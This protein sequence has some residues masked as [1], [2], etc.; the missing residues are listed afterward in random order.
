MTQGQHRSQAAS[1]PMRLFVAIVLSVALAA[2]Q[3]P[4]TT[5]GPVG[6]PG[7]TLAGSNATREPAAGALPAP[8]LRSAD[9]IAAAM[10]DSSRAEQVVVSMLA[11]LGIGLYEPDGS[12]IRAGTETSD[13]DFFVFEPAAHGLANMLRDRT[14]PD[15]QM[16]FR[17]FHAALVSIGYGGSADE[18]ATAYASSYAAHPDAPMSRLVGPLEPVDVEATL[19]S[20]ELWLLLVDG[21]VRPSAAATAMAMSGDGIPPVAAA[22]AGGGWGVARRSVQTALSRPTS[23]RS[24]LAAQ[25]QAI[26]GA[27]RIT[28]TASPVAVHEGHGGPGSPTVVTAHLS[29]PVEPLTSPFTGA[30]IVPPASGPAGL[31]IGWTD[32]AGA[33]KHGSLDAAVTPADEDGEAETTWTPQQEEAD[34]KGIDREEAGQIHGGFQRQ[35]LLTQLYGAFVAPYIGFITRFKEAYAILRIGW[36]EKAEAVVKI[37][38][39]D[40]YDG[41][42][43]TITFLGDLT[44]IQPDCSTLPP[45]DGPCSID[46]A[47]MYMGEGT[48]SGS[49]AGWAA[50]NPG[51]D[52]VPSGTVD[53]TFTAGVDGNT[54]TIG[55]YAN[56]DTN[57]SGVITAPFTVTVDAGTASATATYGP[58]PMVGEL[59]PHNS[60]GTITVT[61]LLLPAP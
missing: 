46:G 52:V 37:V 39:T 3:A 50:C 31:P 40:T 4:A 53:A 1:N 6:S 24:A 33:D 32:V 14:D 48:A 2:C 27:W 42:A 44:D 49:R 57:L 36:H 35:A 60:S 43:D 11:L 38:W 22:I 16:S 21:F 59:C 7:S 41:V 18:L 30:T 58:T 45:P 34:G 5:S 54:I 12:P 8:Q 13:A 56:Y 9:E 17:D 25:L 61:G 28:V 26:V 29:G 55:A 19:P 51:I 47:T 10:S 15:E 23:E 20:F